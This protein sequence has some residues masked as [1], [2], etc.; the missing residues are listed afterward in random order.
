VLNNRADGGVEGAEVHY[1]GGFG[2][3]KVGVWEGGD[4]A[5]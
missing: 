5:R 4:E 1:G 3:G 2:A